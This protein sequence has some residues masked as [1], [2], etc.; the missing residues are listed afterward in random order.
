VFGRAPLAG[1]P[2]APE[3]AYAS[4]L[5]A[6]ST[7]GVPRSPL[8]H[9]GQSLPDLTTIPSGAVAVLPPER[10]SRPPTLVQRVAT[11]E[12]RLAPFK[13]Q[14]SVLMQRDAEA[15]GNGEAGV[16]GVHLGAASTRS[17]PAGSLLYRLEQLEEAMV[18]LLAAQE[19]RARRVCCVWRWWWCC[20]MCSTTDWN[21]SWQL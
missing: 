10:P 8:G 6:N 1:I 3:A 7:F 15:Q 17:A 19:V 4:A 21:H 14:L 2:D 12:A 20:C 18:L 16:N 5:S 11:L 9:A 13:Q